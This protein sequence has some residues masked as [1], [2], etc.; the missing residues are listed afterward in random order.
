MKHPIATTSNGSAVY[1]DLVKSKAATNIALQP[2]LLGLV[3]ELIQQTKLTTDAV[4]MESDMGR[5]L[6]YSAIVETTDK[7]TI[8]YA[9]LLRD[10]TFTR[11]TKNGKALATQHLA[12]ILK[13]DES[14]DYELH[15]TWI[16]RLTPAR[17]GTEDET[18]ASKAFWENHAFVFDGQPLQL[19]TV[20]K[21]CPY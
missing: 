15:D 21:V 20:T 14:G 1:V 5:P 9:Q 16:G 8:L 2:K 12:V 19:R 17:P 18:P 4:H 7:D 13:R 3:K 6:G 11:F 10:D